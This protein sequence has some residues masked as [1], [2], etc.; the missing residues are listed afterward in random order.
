[1]KCQSYSHRLLKQARRCEQVA[2]RLQLISASP[3]SGKTET[4]KDLNCRAMERIQ[5]MAEDKLE[6]EKEIGSR[7]KGKKRI[8][9]GN[10]MMVPWMRRLAAKYYERSVAEKKKAL[11]KR[12]QEKQEAYSKKG[13]GQWEIN[14][15]MRGESASPLAALKRKKKGP[16]GQAPG[17]IT[18]DPEEVDEIIREAYG[19]IYAGNVQEKKV[20]KM[21]D[22]YMEN[23]KSSFSR[24]RKWSWTTS[25][26]R[27]C[28]RRYG[29]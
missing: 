22:D 12:N 21:V 15:S 13:K 20:D 24:P 3:M 19:K 16:R 28:K 26:K 14:K 18:T 23:T 10:I 8:M 5:A 11:T 9:S 1:M 17:T 29:C 4:Y 25:L 7:L 2:Y 6:W 27:T